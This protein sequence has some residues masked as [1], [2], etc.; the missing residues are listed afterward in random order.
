[1]L[2]GCILKNKTKNA[3]LLFSYKKTT[4]KHALV[5]LVS[6]SF[7]ARSYLMHASFKRQ[8]AEILRNYTHN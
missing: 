3:T 6:F 5:E 1:M 8:D 4:I 7:I 2:I